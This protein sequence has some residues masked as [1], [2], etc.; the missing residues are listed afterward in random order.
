MIGIIG[1]ME[2]EINGLVKELAD[3][4]AKK[5]ASLVFYE[6]KLSGKTVVIVKSG[7]GKV[8]AAA[9]TAILLNTY[10]DIEFVIN[11]GI[12]G[13]LKKGARQGD[14]I[15][16]DKSVQHDYDLSPVG[17]PVGLVAG[18][19]DVFFAHDK[20]LIKKIKGFRKGRIGELNEPVYHFGAV[21]S[22]DQFISDNEKVK[23]LQETFSAIAVDMETA[24]IAQVCNLFEV[25][26]LCLRTVSD[27]ADDEAT[28][29]CEE[30]GEMAAKR[31][32]EIV[33]EIIVK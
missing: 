20:D 2:I 10:S 5:I 24:A 33:K 32:I 14:V 16:A 29:S 11:L 27:K 25:K 19:T 18:Y 31:S 4:K 12:C 8:A 15:V 23:Y 9:A 28:I 3:A 17:E 26:F 1:A 13:G 22:G 7:I 21:A 6:G 30:F